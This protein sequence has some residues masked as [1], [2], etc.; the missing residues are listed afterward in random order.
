MNGPQEVFRIAFAVVMLKFVLGGLTILG[1]Q[2][3]V[4]TGSDF[5][6]ALA[7]VGSIHSLSK[8]VDNMGRK[9][10]GEE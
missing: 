10:D 6:L 1:V 9:K 4:F 8:H 2:V 3:P 5:A 7:A